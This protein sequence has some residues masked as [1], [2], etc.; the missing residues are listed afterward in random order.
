MYPTPNGHTC[1]T[2]KNGLDDDFEAVSGQQVAE[3]LNQLR[4]VG[5]VF[6]EIDG[7]QQLI[8]AFAHLG[9]DGGHRPIVIEMKPT[10]EKVPA[11]MLL[12]VGAVAHHNHGILDGLEK[13]AQ[14]IHYGSGNTKVDG[15]RGRSLSLDVERI[16]VQ[17]IGIDAAYRGKIQVIFDSIP[18]DKLVIKFVN[19]LV[20]IWGSRR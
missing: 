4:F 8:V 15:M 7:E 17:Q 12:A 14:Y 2:C 19:L 11:L 9:A 6:L 5:I 3:G 13:A 1:Q 10:V 16:S 20:F 18:V